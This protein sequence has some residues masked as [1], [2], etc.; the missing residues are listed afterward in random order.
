MIDKETLLTFFIVPYVVPALQ[1]IIEGF[2][3]LLTRII[4]TR[5]RIDI[6]NCVREL[7]KIIIEK[8]K[9]R[10]IVISVNS[11]PLNTWYLLWSRG[12][13]I[14]VRNEYYHNK[15]RATY[16][17][18]GL[19]ISIQNL[20]KKIKIN[21]DNYSE[22]N[23]NNNS[24]N[25]NNENNEN[26]EDNGQDDNSQNENTHIIKK[27]K[28]ISKTQKI[29][30]AYFE[31]CYELDELT[32]YLPSEELFQSQKEVVDLLEYTY[33]KRTENMNTLSKK[34]VSA[35]LI[36]KQGTGK[37]NT[38][39]YLT[40]RLNR[41]GINPLIIY[42]FDMTHSDIDLG[43][44]WVYDYKKET[45]LILVLDEIDIAFKYALTDKTY[46]SKSPARN[47]TTLNNLLDHFDRLPYMIVIGTTNLEINEL[48]EKYGAFIRSGRFDYKIH[49]TKN[50]INLLQDL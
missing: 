42:G 21:D 38:A 49:M 43:A 48:N 17:L 24:D 4:I 8:Y 31:G 33:I 19:N 22:D 23:I 32:A 2:W 15:T 1:Y 13:L 41:R 39:L 30:V 47:K 18:Y 36:G 50:N 14:A 9:N 12:P 16:Y 7:D 6:D 25:S 28:K 44:L 3:H 10:E 46:D 45:P 26:L 11:R 37:T 40:E 35:L 34:G 5:V 20:L 27:E 29:K